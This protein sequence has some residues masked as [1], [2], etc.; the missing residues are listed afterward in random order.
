MPPEGPRALKYG[1]SITDACIDWQTTVK[2]LDDL[3]SAVQ[4][5]RQR[6]GTR[7]EPVNKAINGTRDRE[8]SRQASQDF[9]DV[10]LFKTA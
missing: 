7:K 8:M 4:A 6:L 2:V 1:Q 10:S 9:N 5:R 3:R